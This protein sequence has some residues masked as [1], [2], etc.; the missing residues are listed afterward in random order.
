MKIYLD[1]CCYN[2]PFDDFTQP[3]I[4]FEAIAVLYIL[5]Q[6]EK[7][8]Q[9]IIGSDALDFE[10]AKSRFHERQMKVELLYSIATEHISFDDE[11]EKQALSY[12][13]NVHTKLLDSLHLSFAVA[14]GAD[15]LPTTDDEFRKAA[16]K[17]DISVLV[18]NPITFISGERI[19]DI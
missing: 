3:R 13:E 7:G 15:V 1:N 9:E 19:E 14:G 12:I 6:A 2:R 8:K 10:I 11:I 5:M 16:E 4:W 17:L 18:M